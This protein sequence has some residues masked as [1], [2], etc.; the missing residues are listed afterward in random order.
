MKHLKTFEGYE[1]LL[2]LTGSILAIK[3]LSKLSSVLKTQ[4][5]KSVQ[6]P[7][8][9][10]RTT[11]SDELSRELYTKLKKF[12]DLSRNANCEVYQKDN[13]LTVN[14]VRGGKMSL[15]F[16]INKDTN[17]LKTEFGN[18]IRLTSDQV[19]EIDNLV[20]WYKK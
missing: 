16:T 2:V 17:I 6:I 8:E 5:Y 4:Y 14:V 9:R 15:L 3:L 1:P 19:D 18:K 13:I 7:D 10:A 20:Y 12:I 11:D